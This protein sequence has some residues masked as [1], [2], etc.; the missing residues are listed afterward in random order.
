MFDR[1]ELARHI[2]RVRRRQITCREGVVTRDVARGWLSAEP[3][4]PAREFPSASM[5]RV[6]WLTLAEPLRPAE[7]TEGLEAARAA[8]S[9][10]VFIW[11][12]PW[13]WNHSVEAPLHRAGARLWPSVEYI[14]LARQAGDLAVPSRCPFA[15]RRLDPP[16]ALAALA[17]VK[18]WYAP[19]RSEAV[20]RLVEQGVSEV[21]AAF[22]ESTPVAIGLLTVD[23]SWAY[24]G[25]AGTDPR[26]RGRGAQTALI[27]ARAA[28]AQELGA[29]WCASETNTAVPV[30]LRNLR[31]CGF[32]DVISWR[33]YSWDP[34]APR[35][36]RA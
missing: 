24:L 15:I 6:Y 10:R 13:A 30:S 17:E 31:R 18:P 32:E 26:R 22:E 9:R 11:L 27:H 25:S 36:R 7:I 3:A 19:N 28:R 5:D 2:D 4:A 1:A 8:G 35:A 20:E 33:V 23:G 29:P 14:A 12:A 34:G 16:E 21:H